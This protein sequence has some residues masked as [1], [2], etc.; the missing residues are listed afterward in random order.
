MSTSFSQAVEALTAQ[1]RTLVEAAGSEVDALRA[2]L[3]QERRFRRHL[4]ATAAA[5]THEWAE[6]QEEARQ[7]KERLEAAL[8]EALEGRRLAEAQV[9]RFHAAVREQLAI[10]EREQ[11]AQLEA[12]QE[13][14]RQRQEAFARRL[15]EAAEAAARHQEE[16]QE[17]AALQ[18]EALRQELEREQQARLSLE[19]RLSGVR[20]AVLDLLLPTGS[21]DGAEDSEAAE[22]GSGR[23]WR[24]I[25][26]PRPAGQGAQPA[27]P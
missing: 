22:D 7:E 13:R 11:A 15:Q 1:A 9:E 16:L 18:R 4:E 19:R 5:R 26:V 23:G 17:A 2:E 14:E 10:A 6:Q 12:E 21:G 8:A 20:Q 24:K 25:L 3:E 27:L